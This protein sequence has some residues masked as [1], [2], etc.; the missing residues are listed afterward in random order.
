MTTEALDAIH[1][2]LGGTKRDSE[3]HADCPFCGKEAKRAQTHFSYCENGFCCFVCGARG[4]LGKLAEHLRLDAQPTPA[5]R[6]QRQPEPPARWRLNPQRLLAGYLAHPQRIALWQAYKPLSAATLDRHGFGVGRLPFTE[7]G[8]WKMSARDWL[9]VPLWRDGDLMALRG[10]NLGPVGPKWMSATGSH[11]A[12]WNV[13][14][15]RS[16]RT[17][18]LCENYVDAAWLMQDRPNVDAVAIG[19]ATTWRHEWA[20]QLAAQKPLRVVVALDNDLPGQAVGKFRIELENEWRRTHRGPVPLANGPRIANDLRD[21]GVDA[22]LFNW[23]PN[24]PAKAGVDW[25]LSKRSVA[26]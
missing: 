2:A 20:L 5:P 15:V 11:Y 19:G 22:Y 23:P 7:N 16:G 1:A 25:A 14:H 24:A 8:A 12:L 9:T 26:A 4:G 3:W 17:V 21:A 6:P 18:W 13:D 10:R